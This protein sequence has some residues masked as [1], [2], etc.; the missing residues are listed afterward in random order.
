MLSLRLKVILGDPREPHPKRKG[1]PPYV[2]KHVLPPSQQTG[3]DGRCPCTYLFVP[4]A[5]CESTCLAA[6]K[7]ACAP[8]GLQ[9]MAIQNRAEAHR[10]L[11][12]TANGIHLG[13]TPPMAAAGSNQPPSKLRRESYGVVDSLFS[14]WYRSIEPAA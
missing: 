4:G 14:F 1:H 6:P 12:S 5:C 11:P 13:D 8:N 9:D 2:A 3:A 10:L 7:I